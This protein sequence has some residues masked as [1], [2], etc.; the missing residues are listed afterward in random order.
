[1]TFTIPKLLNK[2]NPFAG[3]RFWT[4]LSDVNKIEF[5]FVSC[6]EDTLNLI[7]NIDEKT[8]TVLSSIEQSRFMKIL[9]DN[10]TVNNIRPQEQ[11]SHFIMRVDDAMK[12][13]LSGRDYLDR[14]VQQETKNNLEKALIVFIRAHKIA[15]LP[16]ETEE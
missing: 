6:N 9:L 7:K 5:E 2:K 15:S 8:K 11:P 13:F 16:T 1:V 14:S 10:K 12:E 4:K 3:T